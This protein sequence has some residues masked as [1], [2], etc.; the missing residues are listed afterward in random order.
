M[1]ST[2]PVLGPRQ[3]A[4]AV[5]KVM[6]NKMVMADTIKHGSNYKALKKL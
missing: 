5:T 4:M 3:P 2:Y 1:P 6:H